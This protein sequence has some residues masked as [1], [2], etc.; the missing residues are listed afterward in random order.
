MSKI[1]ED[2]HGRMVPVLTVHI[3]EQKTLTPCEEKALQL[4]RAFLQSVG[5]D[6]A[7]LIV[8]ALPSADETPMLEAYGVY[9][10]GLQSIRTFL[11]EEK[12]RHARWVEEFPDR[13]SLPD[14]GHPHARVRFA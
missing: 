3:H 13:E 1:F 4:T 8:K 5:R 11:S 9:Y 2:R 7:E 10:R 12:Q 14:Y 6:A